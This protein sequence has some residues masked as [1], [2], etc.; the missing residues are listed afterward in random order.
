M[1]AQ[2]EANTTLESLSGHSYPFTQKNT[3][4]NRIMKIKLLQ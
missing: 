1:V 4:A 2:V 3:T